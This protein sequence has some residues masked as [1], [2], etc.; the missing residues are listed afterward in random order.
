MLRIVRLMRSKTVIASVVGATVGHTISSI[1][2]YL[3]TIRKEKARKQTVT[4]L[5]ETIRHHEQ[6]E[7]FVQNGL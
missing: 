4:E 2:G 1:E 5:S 7:R 3:E 6:M